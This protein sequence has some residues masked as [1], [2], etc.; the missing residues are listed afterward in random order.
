MNVGQ[1]TVLVKTFKFQ[2][3]QKSE[4]GKLR[5]STRNYAEF[6]GSYAGVTGNYA[7]VT[8]HLFLQP[9]AND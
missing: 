9:S 6:T 2:N 1:L 8:T 4:S 7:G 5:R 3:L